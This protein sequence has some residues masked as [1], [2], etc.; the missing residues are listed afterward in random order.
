MHSYLRSIGFSHIK[1]KKEIEKILKE[2]EEKYDEKTVVESHPDRMF[3]E[4]SKNF[5][6]DCGITVCGEYDEN[7]VFHREYYFPF[8]RGT[9]ISTQEKITVEK[10]IYR[11]SFAGGCDDLRVGVTLVF[12]LQ[13]AAD[14]MNAFYKNAFQKMPQPVT[15]SGLAR[16]GRILLPVQKDVEQS[17]LE[18]ESSENRKS[19]IAAA[20]TGNEEAIENLT[21]EDIDTYTM[22]SKRIQNEDVF[23]IVDSYFMPYGMECDQYN[24]LGEIVDCVTFKNTITSE[25]VVQITVNCSDIEFDI[26]INRADL[27]GEPKVGR[28]FKGVIWLQGQ[29]QL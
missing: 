21:M 14:Y 6:C 4:F 11:E 15:F 27:L 12:Y 3:A 18:K 2:V 7:N 10:H 23:S 17:R 25:E 26:C 5:A 13:N 16:E 29:L 1:T 28:R 8:F 20:M 9:G 24:V 19:L 22:I